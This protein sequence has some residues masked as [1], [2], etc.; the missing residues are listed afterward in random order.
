MS[1]KIYVIGIGPGAGSLIAPAALEAL[2]RC[3]VAAGYKTYLEL[4]SE[5]TEGKEIISKGMRQERERCLLTLEAA[6]EGKDCALI[7]SGDAGI[8]GMAGL[9]LEIVS[10]AG[11]DVE[12][13]IIPGITA[14]G[15]AAALLGAPLTNDFAVIS[16]SDL[17]TPFE[18]IEKRLEAACIGDFVICLYNP[19]SKKRVKPFERALE[20]MLNYKDDDTPVGIVKSA[21]RKEQEL[22]LLKLSELE[23]NADFVDMF[24]IIIIGNSATHIMDGKMVTKRGYQL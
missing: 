3:R 18:L 5:Y 10:E 24:S 17:L 6:L 11:A 20:I 23:A 15:A 13:E 9:M 14:A 4:V 22:R 19:K 2:E 12:V 8:Y 21:Y 16:L 7:S 1:G